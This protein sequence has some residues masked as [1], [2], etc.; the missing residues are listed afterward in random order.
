MRAEAGTCSSSTRA[1]AR[2]RLTPLFAAGGGTRIAW[3]QMASMAVASSTGAV[4]AAES[5]SPP[6]RRAPRVAMPALAGGEAE[7]AEGAKE[8]GARRL[9][10]LRA[11]LCAAGAWRLWCAAGAA[12][13]ANELLGARG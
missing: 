4:A 10:L 1:A 9:L 5:A 13:D 11:L 6:R 7:E 8:S 12:A 2:L 3:E